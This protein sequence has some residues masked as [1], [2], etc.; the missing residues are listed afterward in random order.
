MPTLV[1]SRPA[2]AAQFQLLQQQIQKTCFS[3][4]FQ[5]GRFPEQLGKSDQVCL[6]KCMDRMME[7]YPIVLRGSSEMADNLKSNLDMN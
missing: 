3:K 2:K 4:C 6:A 1:G 5:D 7:A